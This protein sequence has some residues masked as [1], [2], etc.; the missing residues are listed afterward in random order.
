MSRIGMLQLAPSIE[1]QIS[2]MFSILERYNWF[3]FGIVTSHIAG[4]ENFLQQV[5]ERCALE[6]NRS[7]KE[8]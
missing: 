3:R 7:I 1:H 2:A 5:R 4:H 8:I 6:K